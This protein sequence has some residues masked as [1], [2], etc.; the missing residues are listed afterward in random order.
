MVMCCAPD[1]VAVGIDRYKDEVLLSKEKLATIILS[2][3]SIFNETYY[4]LKQQ[5]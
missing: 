1:I 3:S 5:E 4:F 2:F